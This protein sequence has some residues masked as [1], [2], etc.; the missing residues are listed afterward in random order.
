MHP[1]LLHGK[2]YWFVLKKKK[3]AFQETKGL[4]IGR[5]FSSFLV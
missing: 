5:K 3:K 1:N 4:D 2:K